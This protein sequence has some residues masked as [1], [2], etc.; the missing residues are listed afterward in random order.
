MA[1]L[2]MLT[3]VN[4]GFVYVPAYGFLFGPCSTLLPSSFMKTGPVVFCNAAD[5]QTK[6]NTREY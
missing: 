2:V 4:K 3:K 6:P 1:Q 5:K